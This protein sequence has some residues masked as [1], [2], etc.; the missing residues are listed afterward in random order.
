MLLLLAGLVLSLPGS[1]RQTPAPDLAPA[2]EKIRAEAGVPALGAALVT[3]EGLQGAWVTGTRRAHGEERV[4]LDDRWHL[5]SCTKSMTATLIALLVERGDFAWDTLLPDQLPEVAPDMHLDFLDVTLVDLL[6]HRAGLASSPPTEPLV[7]IVQGGA[8]PQAQRAQFAR[9]VL[10]A[11]PIHPP[12]GAQLYSNS[13]FVIAGHVAEVAAKKPWESLI[14]ELLFQPLGMTSTGFGAPGT[15]EVCDQPR[16]HTGAGEVLEPGPEAD[17][18][19]LI[20]PAGTVHASLADWAKYV[21]LHLLGARGDVKIG[22]LTLHSETFAR[23]HSPAPGPG[24]K[25]GYGWGIEQRAWAGGD[26][27]A[28]THNGSN[29][30]WYC[31]AWLGLGNGVAALVTTNQATP[32]AKSAA[33]QAAVLVLQEYARRLAAKPTTR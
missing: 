12:H 6:G 3:V 4:T 24:P 1:A 32:K 25:Y 33:D 20:G 28:L 21:R 13:G 14:Q 2:L 31:V 5:G 16:G 7:Q 29:T 19:P 23:L 10:G 15:A 9:I 17:N 30:L 27:T 8:A 22:E 11:A 26:G 18:P